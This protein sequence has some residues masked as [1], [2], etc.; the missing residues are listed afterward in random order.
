M[1]SI[2]QLDLG[3]VQIHK[4]VLAQI[5]MTAL[6]EVDGVF[7]IKKNLWQQ[8][9]ELVGVEEVPGIDVEIGPKHEVSI[10]VKVCVRYG[11]HIPDVA[12]VIQSTV[13]K[14]IEKA[15][16]INLKEINVNI[17]GIER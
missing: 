2:H 1:T 4:K 6:T 15:V 13:K 3:A 17:Q 11:L 12:T 9:A 8:C 16:A 5:V 7:P 14:A 10:E